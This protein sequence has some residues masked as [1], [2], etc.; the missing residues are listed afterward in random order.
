MKL[1]KT[2]PATVFSP[3][4]TY[5]KGSALAVSA[6]NA[7][8]PFDVLFE[9]EDFLSLLVPCTVRIITPKGEHEFAIERGILQVTNNVVWLFANV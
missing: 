5:F 2:F 8:G 7:T 9:H 3:F 4:Q 1:Q 6:E